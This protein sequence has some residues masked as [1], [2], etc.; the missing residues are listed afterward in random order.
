MGGF[1][2]LPSIPVDDIHPPITGSHQ[3]SSLRVGDMVAL[4]FDVLNG[5]PNNVGCPGPFG[6]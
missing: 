5:V 3:I 6:G 1:T 2:A 4:R